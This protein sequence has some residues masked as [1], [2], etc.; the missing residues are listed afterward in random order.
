M[1]EQRRFECT[2]MRGGSSKAVFFK[3]DRLPDDAVLRDRIILAAFGSPDVR[4]IDGLGGS[5]ITTSKVAIIGPPTKEDADIDYLFGQVQINAPEVIWNTNCGNISAAVG[6]FAIDEGLVEAQEPYTILRINKLSTDKTIIARVPV[7]GG[8]AVVQ[9]DYEIPGVPGSG[10]K[11]ELDYKECIGAAT[12]RLLP[13][14]NV[15]DILDVPG[16]G[17]VEV[18][19]VDIANSVCFVKAEDIGVNGYMSPP[20]IRGDKEL[21]NKLEAIRNEAAKAMGLISEGDVALEKSPIQPLISFVSQANDYIDYGTGKTIKGEDMDFAARILFNQMPTDS[22][23][24]TA[25][26]CISVASQIKGTVVN[27]IMNENQ[28][29]RGAVNFGH[30]RGINHVEVVVNENNGNITVEKALVGRTA[31]RLMD[32]NVYV[33]PDVF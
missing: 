17:R 32:G 28:V 33:R 29:G 4:Q 1:S 24:I 27:S 14:G 16:I 30:A 13:T 10:A 11:I 3:K 18:S 7:K 25:T 8:K 9:G 5:D 6:P 20:E 19:I 26:I 2:I 21:Q 23:P 22:F 31:R 15:S 12:G